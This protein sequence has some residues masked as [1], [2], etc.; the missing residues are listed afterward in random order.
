MIDCYQVSNLLFIFFGSVVIGS[1]INLLLMALIG[2]ESIQNKV[3][4]KTIKELNALEKLQ[5][6]HI[7]KFH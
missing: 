6:S 4:E 5:S 1:V 2:K 3:Y 7:I